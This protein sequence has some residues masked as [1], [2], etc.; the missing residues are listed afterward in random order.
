MK[1]LIKSISRFCLGALLVGGL[2]SVGCVVSRSKYSSAG[3]SNNAMAAAP[4]DGRQHSITNAQM[5]ANTKS[6]LIS[7]MAD[8]RQIASQGY[9]ATHAGNTQENLLAHP[10]GL[11]FF[12]YIIL[13]IIVAGLLGWMI[14]THSLQKEHAAHR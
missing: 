2:L 1:I 8:R 9:S 13:G 12:G 5:L 10:H 11:L 3:K 6:S 7:P 14:R 4:V